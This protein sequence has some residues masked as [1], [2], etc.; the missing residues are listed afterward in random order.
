MLKFDVFEDNFMESVWRQQ[1]GIEAAPKRRGQKETIFSFQ[2][3]SQTRYG[4]F[5]MFER[6]M[7]FSP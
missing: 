7:L 6:L 5:R 1:W 4:K 3:E 2:I